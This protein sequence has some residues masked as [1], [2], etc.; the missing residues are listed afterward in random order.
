MMSANDPKRTLVLTL[1]MSALER[2]A[3][4]ADILVELAAAKLLSI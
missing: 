4:I 1:S 3:D 2:K